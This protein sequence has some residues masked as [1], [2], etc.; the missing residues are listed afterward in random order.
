M[1]LRP[2]PYAAIHEL[3]PDRQPAERVAIYA[4]SGGIPAYLELFTRSGSFSM[5]LLEQCLGPG[6]IMLTDTSL[7]LHEQ[8]QEPQTF[9]SILSAIA[10]GFHAWSEIARMAGVP[11]SNLGHYLKILQE[12]ELI[13]RRAPIF[14]AAS[15]RQGQYHIRDHFL[16][17]YYRFIVPHITAI[18]RGY[19]QATVDQIT[20]DLRAFVGAYVFEESCREWVFAASALGNLGFQPDTVSAYWRQER[21]AGVQAGVQLDVVAANRRQRRLLIGEA[22]WGEGQVSR[23]ILTDLINRSQRMLQ[24][25]EGWAVDYILFGREGF[26]EATQALATELGVRLVPLPEIERDLIAADG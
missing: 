6:S 24:V 13:E 9:E 25:A 8:L 23:K 2:L 15:G 1:R 21:G 22:K 14:A 5:A 20:A 11:E 17:F 16:R 4:V 26:S 3:F 12:L 19:L 18:E 10:S 7:I